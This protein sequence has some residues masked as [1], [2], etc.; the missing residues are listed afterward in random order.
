MV[1]EGEVAAGAVVTGR[2]EVVVGVV[3]EKADAGEVEVEA[4][5][6]HRRVGYDSLSPGR[7]QRM[8]MSLYKCKRTCTDTRDVARCTP[9]RRTCSSP[10]PNKGGGRRGDNKNRYIKMYD[11]TVSKATHA[12][13][14]DLKRAP[15]RDIY[16]LFH[17]L[18]VCTRSRQCF[19]FPPGRKAVRNV[20]EK[21]DFSTKNGEE[22]LF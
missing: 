7:G 22:I 3:E 16:F 4:P 2:G 19:F 20:V 1:R 8:M 11:N 5:Q 21:F 15:R 14:Y 10:L 6:K 13:T 18:W 9:T 12:C 17:T